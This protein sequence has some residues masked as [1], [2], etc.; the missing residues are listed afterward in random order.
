METPAVAGEEESV[1][2]DA[3]MVG[4]W[5]LVGVGAVGVVG[6]F[7]LLMSFG[8]LLTGRSLDDDGEEHSH[9]YW[10]SWFALLGLTFSTVAIAN[11]LMAV[12]FIREMFS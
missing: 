6:A 7:H 2:L 4:V 12:E 1:Y 9:Y 10:M 3:L 8:A 11:A 5:I